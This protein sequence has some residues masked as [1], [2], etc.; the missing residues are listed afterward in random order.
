MDSESEKVKESRWNQRGS[1]NGRSAPLDID[2]LATLVRE[3]LAEKRVGFLWRGA[4]VF[5]ESC[6][7]LPGF[8]WVHYYYHCH[9]N[10]VLNVPRTYDLSKLDNPMSEARTLH[11]L[12]VPFCSPGVLLEVASGLS[13]SPASALVEGA[14]REKIPV[15]FDASFLSEW[16]EAVR[17][18][19]ER[20]A[21]RR[22]VG[23]IIDSLAKRGME[24]LGL[25]KNEKNAHASDACGAV[26]LG[27]GGWL[28]WSEVAP[29]VTEAKTIFLTGGTKLT[30]EAADRL[31]KLNVKVEEVFS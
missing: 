11:M 17:N 30:A 28:T 10:K 20:E 8:T 27:G 25:E 5:G 16:R 12:V 18:E 2:Q 13:I 3:R 23:K 7:P 19:Q 15:L 4:P 21:R 14:L 31:L 26:R 6:S 1:R 29:L 9:M 22:A 24:F